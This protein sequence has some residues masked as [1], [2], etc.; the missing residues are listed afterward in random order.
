[1]CTYFM[2]QINKHIQRNTHLLTHRNLYVL[3]LRKYGKY[4]KKYNPVTK[5][6]AFTLAYT[7]HSC[8]LKASIS[9]ERPF[10]QERVFS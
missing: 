8:H 1:M 6:E 10:A 4:S 9:Q 7:P 2:K 3:T 5:A